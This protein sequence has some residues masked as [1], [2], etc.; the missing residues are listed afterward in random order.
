MTFLTRLFRHAPWRYAAAFAAGAMIA[1]LSLLL[2]GVPFS[3]GWAARFRCVLAGS[4]LM[5][6]VTSGLTLMNV[7]ANTQQIIKGLL[8]VI[9]VAV[10]FDRRSSAVIQ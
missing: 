5:A 2:G 3:G 7:S 10:S 6:V 9:A 1:L 8:F 4:L